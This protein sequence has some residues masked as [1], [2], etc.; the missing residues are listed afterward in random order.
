[1][2]KS[3]ESEETNM[4]VARFQWWEECSSFA[5]NTKNASCLF[6]FPGERDTKIVL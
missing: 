3:S 2:H 6:S 5:I 4:E 1:M